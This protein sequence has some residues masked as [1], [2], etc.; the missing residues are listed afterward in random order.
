MRQPDLHVKIMPCRM[1]GVRHCDSQSLNSF[2]FDRR[3]DVFAGDEV[4]TGCLQIRGGRV[5]RCGRLFCR[6]WSF[7]S[8]LSRLAF[9]DLAGRESGLQCSRTNSF[10]ASL[11]KRPRRLSISRS[12]IR[13]WWFICR[14]LTVASAHSVSG[15]MTAPSILKLSVQRS[16]RGL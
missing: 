13:S 9:G 16:V 4:S 1:N 15:S 7:R 14:I 5:L 6:R 11:G 10:A 2:M 12:T 8:F 3:Q